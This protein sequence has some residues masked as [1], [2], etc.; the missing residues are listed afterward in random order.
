MKKKILLAIILGMI[1]VLPGCSLKE[2]VEKVKEKVEQKQEEKVMKSTYKSYN[3][4]YEVTV[5]DTWEKAI[6]GDL[7]DSA[8]IELH[9]KDN[10]KY[11]MV[12]AESKVNFDSFD[13]WYG[14]VLKNNI[15]AYNF[16]EEDI[17]DTEVNGYEAKCADFET[18]F[19]GIKMYMRI[20]FVKSENSYSQVFLWTTL[21]KK[22]E[23]TEEFDEIVDTFT[24]VQETEE[25][26]A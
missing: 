15:S 7:N 12:L 22:S 4:K 19:R 23:L 8:D 1:F 9:G 5:N 6:K 10:D 24:E 25:T 2:D 26:E 16:S 3:E 18:S 13:V 14:Y 20:Y 11:F 17:Y 21:D